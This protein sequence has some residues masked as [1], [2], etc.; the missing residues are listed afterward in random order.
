MNTAN[1]QSLRSLFSV[2]PLVANEASQSMHRFKISRHTPA[3]LAN[4]YYFSNTEWMKGY[5]MCHQTAAFKGR[6]QTLM[7]SWQ[8]QIVVDVGCGPGNVYR[9][10]R[11]HCGVPRLLIG[12]DVAE[13]GLRMA[14]SL[15]YTPVLA[16]AQQLPFVSEFADIV[17]ANAMLHHCDDMAQALRESARLVRPGGR[18]IVDHDPQRSMFGRSK[19]AKLIWH[20]RLPL[21]RW[22]KRGGHATADEQLWSTATEAHHKPGDGVDA[23]LFYQVLEPMGFEIRL[24]PHN[25]SVGSEV[26]EGQR[27]F[28]PWKVRWAQRLSGIDPDSVAGA[29]VL[30][31]VAT[32]L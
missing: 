23:E 5:L 2:E 13:G 24:Y 12:I 11:K 29:M 6:W 15:G 28:S 31:C 4:S 8:D 14:Q 18:L 16:D 1:T 30:M 21:Y 20:M 9:A 27:G 22:L 32:K 7:G 10:L 19:M 25:A 26:V 17:V 3:L